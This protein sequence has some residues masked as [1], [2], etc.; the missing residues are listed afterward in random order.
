ML[1]HADAGDEDR[2]G[3]S[4]CSGTPAW[5]MPSRTRSIWARYVGSSLH[6]VLAARAREMVNVGLS[7]RPALAAERA[8]SSRPEGT[9]LQEGARPRLGL[10]RLRCV[11]ISVSVLARAD[12]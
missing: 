9:G 1:A 4:H 11:A 3:R 6:A 12:A 7:A 2:G 8:S 5:R 10:A